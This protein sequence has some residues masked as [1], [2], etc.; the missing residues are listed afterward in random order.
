ME[1][2]QWQS[3]ALAAVRRVDY[4]YVKPGRSGNGP[5][6]RIPLITVESYIIARLNDNRRK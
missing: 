4:S 2:D 1:E 3:H 5:G 6:L